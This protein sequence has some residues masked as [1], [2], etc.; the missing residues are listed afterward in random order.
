M[1]LRAR[2]LASTVYRRDHRSKRQE[3]D[4]CTVGAGHAKARRH[5]GRWMEQVASGADAL[6]RSVERLFSLE[7]GLLRLRSETRTNS[8]EQ[9]GKGH[10]EPS[11]QSRESV[12]REIVLA[13]LDAANMGPVQVAAFGKVLLRQLP[14][15]S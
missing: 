6:Q 5:N 15:R 10:P 7:V 4:D 14:A 12:Q 9:L 8:R 13:A 2:R 3:L 1:K 11:G